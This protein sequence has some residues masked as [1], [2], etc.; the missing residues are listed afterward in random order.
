MASPTAGLNHCGTDYR[1]RELVSENRLQS[2]ARGGV[3]ANKRGLLSQPSP[4]RSRCDA[5]HRQD[6]LHCTTMLYDVCSTRVRVR[7]GGLRE[8][9]EHCMDCGGHIYSG[10]CSAV[11]QPKS[12]DGVTATCHDCAT[13]IISAVP[14]VRVFNQQDL[15]PTRDKA[16]VPLSSVKYELP[17]FGARWGTKREQTHRRTNAFVQ[18]CP[19]VE[20]ETKQKIQQ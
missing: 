2:S 4:R 19:N 9:R 16:A 15:Q 7:A 6:T 17:R 13:S 5:R 8:R 20:L 1:R 3:E 10:Q 18:W 14:P 11:H 12:F